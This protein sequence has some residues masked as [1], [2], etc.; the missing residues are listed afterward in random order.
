MSLHNVRQNNNY[1]NISSLPF[2]ETLLNFLIV[3]FYWQ[4]NI[5]YPQNL[6]QDRFNGVWSSL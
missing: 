4:R 3:G 2:A 5:R 1:F 6:F